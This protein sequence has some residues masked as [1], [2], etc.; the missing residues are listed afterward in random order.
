MSFKIWQNPF[1]ENVGG[2]EGAVFGV[3]LFVLL[4]HSADDDAR[5][6]EFGIESFGELDALGVFAGH[7]ESEDI[8]T[9]GTE[10]CFDG[11]D[12]VFH[13]CSLHKIIIA[14]K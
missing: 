12:F 4:L 1:V 6:K 7:W 13:C 10:P 5:R 11:G 14:Y 2:N 8:D 9:A 3:V